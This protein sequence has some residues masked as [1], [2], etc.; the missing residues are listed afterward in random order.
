M[1]QAESAQQ[2]SQPVR[3]TEPLLM[4]WR[5]LASA[6]FA[7]A[8]IGFLFSGEDPPTS[9][10]AADANDDGATDIA[11]VVYLLDFLFRGRSAPPAPFPERGPDPE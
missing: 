3:N 11:D 8:L 9:L 1:A 4:L 7:I 10:D 5:L 6:Q 2:V